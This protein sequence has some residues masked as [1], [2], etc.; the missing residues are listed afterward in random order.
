MEAK[1][2]PNFKTALD[3]AR[4]LAFPS[5]YNPTKTDV[6]H[7]KLTYVYSNAVPIASRLDIKRE[8]HCTVYQ[9]SKTKGRRSRPV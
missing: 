5:F 7:Q 3:M 8:M 4:S 9:C 6:Q 1:K 2:I